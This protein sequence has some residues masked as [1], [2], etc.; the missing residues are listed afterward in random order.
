[1]WPEGIGRW[2]CPCTWYWWGCTSS[3]VFSFGPLTTR[4]TLS[5]WS[6]TEEE[7]KSWWRGLEHKCSEERLRDLGLFSLE[8]KRLSGDLIA[9]YLKG[10]GSELNV[11][12]SSP[13]YQVIR[14]E[15]TASS[16]S[17]G[18]LDLILGKISSL[19]GLSSIGIG[20]PGKS[21]SHHPWR[22]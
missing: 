17:R 21:W 18:D 15:E 19:K 20:C 10:D 13:K 3:T 1:V 5:C 8:K 16:C 4:R 6:L 11:E 12:I 9:L 7:Q 14:E 2:S 22:N